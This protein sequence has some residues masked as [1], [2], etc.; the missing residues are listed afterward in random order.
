[1]IIDI[2]IFMFLAI[3]CLEIGSK[4]HS[5]VWVWLCLAI[6]FGIIGFFLFLMSFII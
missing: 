5:H 4:K 3:I 6:L 2:L 1:M